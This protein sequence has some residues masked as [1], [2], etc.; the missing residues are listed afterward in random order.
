MS[1]RWDNGHIGDPAKRRRNK[2]KKERWS[3]RQDLHPQPIAYKAIALLLSY[4]SGS[5]AIWC[6][7]S[8]C[9]KHEGEAS[10]KDRYIL[11]LHLNNITRTMCNT[12]KFTEK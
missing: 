6:A 3:T 8:T 7:G 1:C 9:K 4:G 11:Y 2:R 5:P 10:M 12:M